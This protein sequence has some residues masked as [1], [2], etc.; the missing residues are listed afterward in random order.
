[1]GPEQECISCDISTARAS[2]RSKEA[3]T[4]GTYASKYI[5]LD[6]LHL[7]IRVGLTRDTTFPFYLLQVNAYSRYACIY[8]IK[9][10]SSTCIIDMLT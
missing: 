7:V 2:S 10:K 9:D 8:G 4:G 1:M 3:H 6:I 5:F